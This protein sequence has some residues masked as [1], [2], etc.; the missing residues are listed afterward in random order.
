MSRSYLAFENLR[1]HQ[2]RLND[3][4]RLGSGIQLAAWSNK[5]D[6]ITQCCDHH[7]LSLYTA[8]GYETYHKTAY[9]WRNGGGPDRFCLM[10]A[11]SESTWDVRSDLSFV[12]LY[13]TAEHLQQIALRIWDRAPAALQLDERIFGE[14]PG[15]TQLYR[16][17]LLSC[18]WQQDANQ[19]MLS[20]SATL[21]L[22]HLLQHYSSVRWQPPGIRGG[23]APVVLR[24]V[25]AFI[26]AHLDA[27]LTL[28]TLAQEAG[29]S[30]YHFARMFKQ[31]TGLAPHQ[32]VMA[33][34]MERAKQLLSHSSLPLT[35]IALQCG[36]SSASHFSNR[37]RAQEG[38]PPSAWRGR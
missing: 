24:R 32:Y 35:E 37:F 6:I 5:H 14:D 18:D 12:H 17:F 10:P 4:V 16:H 1:R 2:A 20:T 13:C 9:G 36:F 31:D 29:L 38:L 7:T 15:I 22:T 23:L 33:R 30:E 27:P 34:R 3:S 11:Q 8:D 19:L 21:L 28:E 25:Q 26:E